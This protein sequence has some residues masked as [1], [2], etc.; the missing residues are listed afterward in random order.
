MLS[1]N[2]Q[3]DINSSGS[4][5]NCISRFTLNFISNVIISSPLSKPL[6]PTERKKNSLSKYVCIT[7]M[8][9]M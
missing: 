4:K 6:T 5:L 7:L 2:L 1:L 8:K 3:N 9:K